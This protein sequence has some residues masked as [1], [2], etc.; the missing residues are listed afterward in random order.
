MAA[1]WLA[2]RRAAVLLWISVAACAGPNSDNFLTKHDF[3]GTGNNG[4]LAGADLAGADLT[5]FPPDDM[6]PM[7]DM[8]RVAWTDKSFATSDVLW[9][10]W[11]DGTAVWVVGD[12]F[13]TSDTGILLKAPNGSTFASD[14]AAQPAGKPPLY[15]IF[16]VSS[17]PPGNPLLTVGKNGAIWSLGTNPAPNGT[18]SA[19]PNAGTTN[20]TFVWVA[21]DGVAFVVGLGNTAKKQNG[22][23]WDNLTGIT[24]FASGLWGVKTASGYTVY[25]CGGTGHIW[26]YTGTNFVAENTGVSMPTIYGIYGFG[27]NDIYAV[28]EGGLIL[29]S[30][31]T[32]TWSAQTSGVSTSLNAV[33]GAS[34]DEVYAVGDNGVVLHKY[35][36]ASTTWVKETLANPAENRNFV[37]VWANAAK[38]WVTG[39]AGAILTK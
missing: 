38:V 19:L 16:G 3:A 27:E 12:N 13:P 39:Y 7:G 35:G 34:A 26:K 24:D 9:S 31:G 11:S 4:D 5:G 30:T 17:G 32:G 23:N 2:A 8:S 25:A 21:P 33:G 1:P 20:Y 10:V 6:M 18:W 36:A 14:P 22:A 37:A 28:G 15:G 29:H